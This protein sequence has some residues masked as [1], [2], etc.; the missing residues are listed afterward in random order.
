MKPQLLREPVRCLVCR[1]LYGATPAFATRE[2]LPTY[3]IVYRWT[4]LCGHPLCCV[5]GKIVT[6]GRAA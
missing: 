4:C 6:P 1:S 3:E 2:V 5:T